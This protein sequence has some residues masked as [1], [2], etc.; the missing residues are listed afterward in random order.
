MDQV[1]NRAL[2]EHGYIGFL[3]SNEYRWSVVRVC[4][5]DFSYKFFSLNTYKLYL[6]ISDTAEK[7]DV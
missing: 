2:D 7:C 3:T 4:V 5:T 1:S 6:R